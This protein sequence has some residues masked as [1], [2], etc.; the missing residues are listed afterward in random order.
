MGSNNS[1]CP[2]FGL[3]SSL[4]FLIKQKI[5]APQR[6]PRPDVRCHVAGVQSTQTRRVGGFG[7]ET[8]LLQV[9]RFP[10]IGPATIGAVLQYARGWY[11]QRI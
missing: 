3:F 10:V 1:V 5:A 9:G 11:N 4:F 7:R 2:V 8:G 6:I